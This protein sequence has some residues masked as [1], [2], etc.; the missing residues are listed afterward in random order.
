LTIL[1]QHDSWPW[2]EGDEPMLDVA[3]VRMDGE[4][5]DVNAL[6]RATAV[7]DAQATPVLASEVR[8]GTT[9]RSL[10]L[11]N[12]SALLRPVP[13]DDGTRPVLG[14]FVGAWDRDFSPSGDRGDLF[15]A[16]RS[17][18]QFNLDRA[19]RAG[20]RLDF[21]E[22]AGTRLTR[23]RWFSDD[24]LGYATVVFT[25]ADLQVIARGTGSSLMSF[26][27]NPGGD[28][29]YR[30]RATLDAA[31]RLVDSCTAAVRRR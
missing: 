28:G 26:S 29:N 16:W 14:V 4:S 18:F 9:L 24:F 31:D 25:W 1:D 11:R 19:L 8:E 17:I 10:G 12:F 13:G 15:A 2:L 21:H 22:L 20:G 23:F 30:V 6:E 7:I 5:V 3:V 27:I